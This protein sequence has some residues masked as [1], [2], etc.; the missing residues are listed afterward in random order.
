MRTKSNRTTADE[1]SFMRKQTLVFVKDL[2]KGNNSLI[3]RELSK[4]ATKEEIARI[5]ESS[6]QL[7]FSQGIDVTPDQI[8]SLSDFV[9]LGA[10]YPDLVNGKVRYDDCIEFLN[11]L[12]SVFKWHVYEKKTLGHKN[13]DYLTGFTNIKWYATI[14]YK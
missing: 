9:A 1:F 3:V 5:I 10:K 6:H 11:E 8:K 4:Y 12:S 7:R 13:H 2:V 14:L